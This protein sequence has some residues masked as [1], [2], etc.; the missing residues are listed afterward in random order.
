MTN[1]NLDKIQDKSW[2]ASDIAFKLSKKGITE[3]NICFK[4]RSG[5]EAK[6][7]HRNAVIYNISQEIVNDD[8]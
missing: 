6:I 2:K 4:D 3:Q 8:L 5:L 1:H 7:F